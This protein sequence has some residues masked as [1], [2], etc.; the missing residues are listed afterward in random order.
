MAKSGSKSK[1]AG[2]RQP[3]PKSDAIANIMRPHRHED[4]L[5]IAEK[6]QTGDDI[7]ISAINGA[8]MSQDE[9]AAEFKAYND[10]MDKYNTACDE[11]AAAGKD[12][13]APPAFPSITPVYD[14]VVAEAINKLN[15]RVAMQ[16]QASKHTREPADW[17]SNLGAWK[18]G[19]Y[20]D[21]A[22]VRMNHIRDLTRNV[23]NPEANLVKLGAWTFLIGDDTTSAIFNASPSKSGNYAANLLAAKRLSLADSKGLG[24]I[25]A[26]FNNAITTLN[27]DDGTKPGGC[28]HFLPNQLATWGYLERDGRRLNYSQIRKA[29]ESNETGI[30]FV[31]LDEPIVGESFG[32]TKFYSTVQKV[33]ALAATRDDTG[34]TAW[35]RY[36]QRGEKAKGANNELN[37]WRN[38]FVQMR[39]S[40]SVWMCFGF[41]NLQWGITPVSHFG[42]SLDEQ[43]VRLVVGVRLGTDYAESRPMARLRIQPE[44]KAP[45]A[46]KPKAEKKS[47]KAEKPKRTAVKKV[48]DGKAAAKPAKPAK[49]DKP[50]KPR[51]TKTTETSAPPVETTVEEVVDDISTQPIPAFGGGIP[52]EEVANEEV[53][54]S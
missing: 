23:V 17:K 6:L 3:R 18:E 7:S 50:K 30:K 2:K 51:K 21:D 34:K 8:L 48:D 29:A 22:G 41:E 26:R 13:P 31:E 1:G 24:N 4:V 20:I 35:D 37:V 12:A 44:P 11:A 10:A 42:D 53:A 39:V 46:A 16:G 19:R 54:T 32:K 40:P 49:P 47:E 28:I 15:C 33:M 52:H 43:L 25:V 5:A 9:V 45:K 14:P 38:L 36:E 27:L